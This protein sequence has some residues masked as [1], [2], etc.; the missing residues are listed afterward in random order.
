MKKQT[1]TTGLLMDEHTQISYTEICETYEI[2][3]AFLQ[4]LAEHGLIEQTASNL[5]QQTFDHHTVTRIQSA[6]RIQ[7]DLGV[8]TPGVVLAIELLEELEQ[9][10]DELN[11]LKRHLEE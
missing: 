2:D 7:H 9:L 6:R 11:I 3:E 8:N 10:R 5:K 1:I 4:E